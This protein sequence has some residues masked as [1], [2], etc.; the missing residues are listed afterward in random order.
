MTSS[1]SRKPRGRPILPYNCEKA[2]KIELFAR[3]H[4]RHTRH[5]RTDFRY[6][7]QPVAQPASPNGA[8]AC[9]GRPWGKGAAWSLDREDPL[10]RVRRRASSGYGS[11]INQGRGI[12]S[13]PG[14]LHLAREIVVHLSD[15]TTLSVG[16]TSEGEL[17]DAMSKGS[18]V[19]TLRD[20]S[21]TRNLVNTAHIV[22]VELRS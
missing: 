10:A 21:G 18:R 16:S 19:V 22:R 15:R 5:I 11:G 2:F 6:A 9:P 7:A 14:E 4:R 3:R 20:S 8:V 1:V 17:S 12:V 13:L